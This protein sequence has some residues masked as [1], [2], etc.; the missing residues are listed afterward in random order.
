MSL[1]AE[2]L[3]GLQSISLTDSASIGRGKTRCVGGRKYDRNSCRGLYHHERRG[4]PAWIQLVADNIVASYP[5]S[6]LRFQLFRDQAVSDTLYH[7]LG[8]HRHATVGSA[9]R[10]GEQAAED[11]RKRLLKIHARRQYWYLRPIAPP[12][13]ALL[14][15]LRRFNR[16]GR[17]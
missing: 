9:T 10:G 2:H 16:P 13:T 14:R 15:L 11:W 4:Q 7:E 12:V 5:A 8:H 17:V 6:L 1:G 3:S